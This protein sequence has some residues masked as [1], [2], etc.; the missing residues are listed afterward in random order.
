MV[1]TLSQ[2][3]SL[4]FIEHVILCFFIFISKQQMEKNQ[5]YMFLLAQRM[6]CNI[7]TILQTYYLLESKLSPSLFNFS[8]LKQTEERR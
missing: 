3:I 1:Q 6:S 5:L 2:R 7:V 8:D 4:I